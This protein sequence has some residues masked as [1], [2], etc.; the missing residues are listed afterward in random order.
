MERIV[1]N[2]DM[3]SVR[4]ITIW[5]N[6]LCGI[7][8]GGKFTNRF[9]RGNRNGIWKKIRGI[10]GS[11]VWAGTTINWNRGEFKYGLP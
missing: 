8:R 3:L 11:F 5:F 9:T 10:P 2:D 7:G 1:A 4:I 6:Q